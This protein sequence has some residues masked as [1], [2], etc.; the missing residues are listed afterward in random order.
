MTIAP[1]AIEIVR[2]VESEDS[3]TLELKRLE[4]NAAML[5]AASIANHEMERRK[6]RY[7]RNEVRQKLRDMRLEK[8]QEHERRRVE[9]N[10]ARIRPPKLKP[11]KK[12][13]KVPTG[14][15]S[16]AVEP[17]PEDNENKIG[18]TRN[19]DILLRRR[20][21]YDYP[22][23]DCHHINL[24]FLGYFDELTSLTIEFLGPKMEFGYHKLHTRFSYDDISNLAKGVRNLQ[25][26]KVFRLRNSLMD[27]MKLIII[28]KALRNL[29]DLE[30][31][32][33]GCDNLDDDCYLSL[34]MLLDRK[35]MLK[36]LELEYNMLGRNVMDSIG[37][38]LLSQYNENPEVTALEY[39]GLAHNLLPGDGLDN[40]I[41]KIIGTIHIH[42]LNLNGVALE[43]DKMVNSVS[44][45][46]RK[47][48]PLRQL[49]MAANPLNPISGKSLICALQTNHK[50][51]HFDCRGCNL[52]ENQEYEAD[53]I[54]RRNNYET[55]NTFLGD[56]SI[57]EEMLNEIVGARRNPIMQ[58]IQ[59]YRI[60]QI[61]CLSKRPAFEPSY[62]ELE[63]EPE[64]LE[65]VESEESVFNIWQTLA[66]RATTESRHGT[67]LLD[68]LHSDSNASFHFNANEF[69]I[70]E[71]REHLQMPGPT[72]RYYFFQNQKQ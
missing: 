66:K 41:H 69:T 15:F 51:I 36:S 58:K 52:S 49:Q 12:K 67:V 65:K 1:E 13:E 10:L 56:T 40:F 55:V 19:K 6:A 38:V 42:K 23:K 35:N 20:K 14:V 16:I 45:L 9:R 3:E 54:V 63:V 44:H 33:F 39:L 18:D 72:N 37:N 60:K 48:K 47:H 50:I 30:V 27:S 25:Q 21:R 71:V 28:I 46:L 2:S 43:P 5:R 70:S 34:N 22:H 8:K 57:T 7:E 32:D 68:S 61:E 26:L 29:E 59:D 11:S 17:E 4:E 64:K 24:S 62:E 31:V 53:V